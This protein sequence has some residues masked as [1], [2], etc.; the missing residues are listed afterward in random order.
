MIIAIDIGTTNLKIGLYEMDGTLKTV[1]VS[2]MK[3]DMDKNVTYYDPHVLRDTIG[4]QII[5]IT[6]EFPHANIEAISITSMAESGLLINKKSGEVYTKILP[7]FEKVSIAQAKQIEREIDEIQQFKKTG[8]HPSYKYGLAKLLWLKE[9]QP[10]LFEKDVVWLSVSSYI[11]YCLTG[12]IVEEKSLAARTYVFDIVNEDWNRGLIDRFGFNPTLFPDIIDCTTAVGHVTGLSEL[13]LSDE[14]KVYI[15]GHDHL[16]ASLSIGKLNV[17]TVFNSIGTAETLI[18]IFPK[19]ELTKED[20]ESGLTF[21]I[22]PLKNFYYWMGGHSSSGDS[23]EWI[24]GIISDDF[25]TYEG[26]N[27]LLETTISGPTGILYFPYLNGSGAPYPNQDSEAAFIGMTKKH[28]KNDILKAVLEGNAF[29]MELIRNVAEHRTQSTIEKLVV[30]GGG[31]Q[32]KH[33]MQIKANVSGI[34]LHLPVIQEAALKG[35]MIIAATGEGLYQ[36]LDQAVIEC[37]PENVEFIH[38]QEHEVVEYQEI[39]KRFERMRALLY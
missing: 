30:V 21:G 28:N 22:H 13:G 27:R 7:W 29:Q 38:P 20:R 18:G 39:F 35:A 14:T 24:R 26:V 32:N 9:K 4:S 12:K 17:N 2:S 31:V 36:S 10:F 8:L 15:A 6:K 5:E 16:V 25:L 33:W 19:R 11:A 1:K 37:A 3:K 23:V 34:S